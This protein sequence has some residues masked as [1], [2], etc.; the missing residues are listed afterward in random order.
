MKV[1]NDFPKID[2]VIRNLKD[3]VRYF[4]KKQG[5]L[6]TSTDERAKKLCEFSLKYVDEF[7]DSIQKYLDSVC[8]GDDRIE[9]FRMATDDVAQ[10]QDAIEQEDKLRTSRHSAVI[11][12][13]VMI[14]RA[15]K[16]EN[17]ELV[18]NYADEFIQDYASLMPNT[19]QEKSKMSERER[20]KRRELGNF[21]LYIAASVTAGLTMDDREI[22]EFANCEG[23]VPKVDT[24]VFRNVKAKSSG[25]KRNIDIM[26]E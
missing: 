20:I 24:D 12:S 19:L 3:Y 5:E 10:I 16:R 17:M 6:K 9:K 4:E 1:K 22:R 11:K 15:C 18:F 26:L 21:G 23:D 7:I 13:M 2:T 14:D 25:V 8:N